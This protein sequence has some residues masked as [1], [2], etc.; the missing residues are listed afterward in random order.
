MGEA[1]PTFCHRE[2][3]AIIVLHGFFCDRTRSLKYEGLRL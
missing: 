3:Y 2:V 1:K